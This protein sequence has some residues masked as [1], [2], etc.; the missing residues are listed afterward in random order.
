MSLR[1]PFDLFSRLPALA[2]LLEK[3][4]RNSKLP[5]HTVIHGLLAAS[6]SLAAGTLGLKAKSSGPANVVLVVVDG[7]EAALDVVSDMRA[8][9]AV[10]EAAQPHAAAG[11]DN[12]AKAAPR[13]S[14]VQKDV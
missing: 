13:K 9:M 4:D 6:R 11:K 2:S 5:R 1:S 3:P 14:K 7:P 12:G 8:F 10:E